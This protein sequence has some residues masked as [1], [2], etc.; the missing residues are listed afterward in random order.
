MGVGRER[1]GSDS[2]RLSHTGAEKLSFPSESDLSDASSMLLP[3]IEERSDGH[4]T[5]SPIS[6]GHLSRLG[7]QDDPSNLK[8]IEEG[9]ELD[10]LDRPRSATLPS[11]WSGCG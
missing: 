2:G 6:S 8:I 11:E 1:S 4:P 10:V 5:H 9:A 3:Q 7:S